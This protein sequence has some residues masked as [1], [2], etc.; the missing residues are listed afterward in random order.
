LL[1]LFR[2]FQPFTQTSAAFTLSLPCLL[3]LFHQPM[4]LH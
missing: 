4:Q 2:T 1:N 3:L